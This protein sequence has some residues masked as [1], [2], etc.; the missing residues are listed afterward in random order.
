MLGKSITHAENRLF[1]FK[2]ER[3]LAARRLDRPFTVP[4]DFDVRKYAGDRLFIA[5]LH[6]VQVK[7][8]LR[9][10]SARRMAGWYRNAKAER[11]GAVVVRTREVLTG[12]LA[13]WI[14]RQGPEVEVLSPPQLASWVRALARRVVEA[15]REGVATAKASGSRNGPREPA[16]DPPRS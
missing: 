8:R 3:I 2:V 5:G 7:L 9:G 13:A 16:P 4:K 14:L 11:G 15:H 6:P 1:V 12:W 10:A